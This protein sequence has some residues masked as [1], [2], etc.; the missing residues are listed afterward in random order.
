MRKYVPRILLWLFVIN[1]ATAFGA[2]IYESR[3]VVPQ[4]QNTPPQTWTNTGLEFWVYVTTVPFTLLTLANLVA[5]W[6]E[7]GQDVIGGSAHPRSASWSGSGPSRT[8][9]RRYSG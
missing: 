3:V 8:S 7:R 6:R 5:A 1:L 4:W 2:G 9:F